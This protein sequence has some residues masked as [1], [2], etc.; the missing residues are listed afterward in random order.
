MVDHKGLLQIKVQRNELLDMLE[1]QTIQQPSIKEKI[2]Y[3]IQTICIAWS[4]ATAF[5]IVLILVIKFRE[6]ILRFLLYPKETIVKLLLK[7]KE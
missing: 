3:N 4:L 2:E 5:I 6:G 1:Q 7:E